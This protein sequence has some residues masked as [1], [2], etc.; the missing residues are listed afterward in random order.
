MTSLSSYT[1]NILCCKLVAIYIIK[2]S[3]RVITALFLHALLAI[4][5]LAKI[6]QS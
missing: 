3:L 6:K 2:L 4:I 5:W 1:I